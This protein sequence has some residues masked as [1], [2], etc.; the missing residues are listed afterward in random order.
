MS[1]I[2]YSF[3]IRYERNKNVQVGAY[4]ILVC[5]IRHTKLT[6][7]NQELAPIIYRYIYKI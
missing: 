5:H 3:Y 1:I 2:F 4:F 6:L 7:F